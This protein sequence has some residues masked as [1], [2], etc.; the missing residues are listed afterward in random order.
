MD[1]AVEA[2]V[3]DTTEETAEA[4]VVDSA[5]DSDPAEKGRKLKKIMPRKWLL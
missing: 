3:A 2:D 5:E 4:D 1:A